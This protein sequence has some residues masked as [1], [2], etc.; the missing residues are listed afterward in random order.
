M[1]FLG[2]TVTL[3]CYYTNE[4]YI[5]QTDNRKNKIQNRTE[6][7]TITD[8]NCYERAKIFMAII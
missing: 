5:N 8:N 2:S 4:P 3:I 1:I 6:I 7:I